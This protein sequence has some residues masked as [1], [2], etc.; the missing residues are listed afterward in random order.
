MGAD[1]SIGW[2]ILHR[3]AMEE[4]DPQ[5]LPE[6]IALA[7]AAIH[8]RIKHLKPNPKHQIERQE[9]DDA[10]SSLR[11]MKKRHLPGWSR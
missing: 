3:E 9:L 7:E 4:Q 6:K 2:R 10:L 8:S 11:A 1:E 5:Q